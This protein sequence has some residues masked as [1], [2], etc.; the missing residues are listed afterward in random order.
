MEAEYPFSVSPKEVPE[1]NV[2]EGVQITI[3]FYPEKT[4]HY[5]GKL[6]LGFD[7]INSKIINLHGLGKSANV[8]LDTNALAFQN[9]YITCNT[10]R[11]MKIVN[12]SNIRVNFCWKL[13]S[14]VDD[15]ISFKTRS[16]T[17]LALEHE[18]T[19]REYRIKKREI[20]NDDL[21]FRDDAFSIYPLKGEIWPNQELEISVDFHPQKEIDYDK[22]AFCE[23]TGREIRLP[24]RL[25]GRGRG[26]NVSFSYTEISIGEIFINSVHEY[27][28]RLDNKGQIGASFEL[29]KPTSLF[30]P[31]FQFVPA[32]GY[33]AATESQIIKIFFSSDII[34]SFEEDIYFRIEGR[35]EDLR[36][37][38]SGQIIGPTFNFDCD[39]LNFGM[40][41]YGFLNTK[42]VNIINTCEIP[43]KFNLRIPEDGTMLKRQFDIIP[44]N[45]SILPHAKKQIKIEY[46]STVLRENR[47]TLVVDVEGVGDAL[48]AIP[49][50]AVTVAP[51][52][53]LAKT[54]I[55]FGDC[56][57]GYEYC[58]RL[59]LVNSTS[60]SSK[61]E[62]ILPE[63]VKQYD[64]RTDSIMGIVT[65]KSSAF[66][67]IYFK[68]K[69]LGEISFKMF[70]KV[71]GSEQDP[72]EVLVTAHSI[73]PIVRLSD[74]VIDFGKVNVLEIQHAKLKMSNNSPIPANYSAQ[75]RGKSA[76]IFSSQSM[77]G[78]IEPKGELDFI[79][80]AILDD[81]VKFSD[82]LLLTIE[83]GEKLSVK[84]TAIGK[85]NT[86]IPTEPIN[87]IDFG[88]Q[89]TSRV[90]KK[91][92]SLENKSRKPQKISWMQER[93]KGDQNVPVFKIS[94]DRVVIPPK[95]LQAFTIEGFCEKEGEIAEPWICKMSGKKDIVISNPVL[96]SRISIPLLKFSE[97][98]LSFLYRYVKGVPATIQTKTVDVTNISP[99]PLTF[100]VK[101]TPPF[102][103]SC[104]DYTI[105]PG[106]VKTLEVQF[107]P[108][109]KTDKQSTDVK[110]KM[111]ITYSDHPNKSAI[112][113]LGTVVFPNLVLSSTAIDFGTVVADAE[114]SKTITLENRGKL[115]A[116]FS[117]IFEI[118]EN[119]DLATSQ[120]FDILPMN[121]ILEPGESVDIRFVYNA[122]KFGVNTAT[123]ICEVEGGPNYIMNLR[124]ESSSVKFGVDNSELDYGVIPYYSPQ[125]KDITISNTGKIAI[126]FN[127]DFGTLKRKDI[128]QVIPESGRI[129]PGEKQKLIVKLIPGIPEIINEQFTLMVAMYEP[130]IV[131]VKAVSVHPMINF[132]TKVGKDDQANAISYSNQQDFEKHLELAQKNASRG[133]TLMQEALKKLGSE[134]KSTS[135]KNLSIVQSDV[136]KEAERLLF[137]EYLLM[138]SLRNSKLRSIPRSSRT[139]TPN[140]QKLEGSDIVLQRVVVDFGSTI[141]GL[142]KKKTFKLTNVGV[143]PVYLRFDKKELAKYG[144]SIEPSEISNLPGYPD[145]QSTPID[146]IFQSKSERVEIGEYKAIIPI[147]VLNGYIIEIEARANVILPE[148]SISETSLNFGDVNVGYAK[149]YTIQIYNDKDVNSEWAIESSNGR[150]KDA[151]F[152]FDVM[153][154]VLS[155]GEKKNISITFMPTLDKKLSQTFFL[156]CNYNPQPTKITCIGNGK[157]LNIKVDYVE[158]ELGPILPYNATFI[159]FSISN[160]SECAIDVY[161]VDFDE[162]YRRESEIILSCDNFEKGYILAKP[163]KFGGPL[164]EDILQKYNELV[165]KESGEG[166]SQ[167]LAS[168]RSV[169]TT[170][171]EPPKKRNI[172]VIHGPP[173]S[174]KSEIATFISSKLNIPIITIDSAW[175]DYCQAHTDDNNP[176]TARPSSSKTKQPNDSRMYDKLGLALSERFSQNDCKNGFIIDGLYSDRLTD[177]ATIT[178]LIMEKLGPENANLIC[179]DANEAEIRSRAL[180]ER[181]EKAKQLME[182]SR[183]PKL[184][185]E[186]YET[187]AENEKKMYEAQIKTFREN[188]MQYDR[189]YADLIRLEKELAGATRKYISEVLAERRKE[190]EEYMKKM[191]EEAKKKKKP[192]PNTKSNTTRPETPTNEK[193]NYTTLADELAVTAEDSLFDARLKYFKQYYSEVQNSFKKIIPEEPTTG[194][195]KNLPVKKKEEEIVENKIFYFKVSGPT[196]PELFESLIQAIPA[197]EENAVKEPSK[198]M[199]LAIP[200]PY[201]LQVI[202]KPSQIQPVNTTCPFTIVSSS[203]NEQSE[204]TRWTISPGGKQEL[205]IKFTSKQIGKFDA[206]LTFGIYG[207]NTQFSIKTSGSC[208]YP[209]ISTYYKNIFSRRIKSRPDKG[210]A[211]KYVINENNYEF[212]PLLIRPSYDNLDENTFKEYY[213]VFRFTNSGKFTC[214]LNFSLEKEDKTFLISPSQLSIN[215][216]A[217][218]EVKVWALPKI[219]GKLKN[220][221]ICTV[222]NNPTPF[223]FDVS[224]TGSKPKIELDKTKIDFGKVLLSSSG[225]TEVINMKN[226]AAIP[227][228]WSIKNKAQIKKEFTVE[229]SEGKLQPGDQVAIS[230]KFITDIACELEEKLLLAIS[231]IQELLPSEETPIQLKAD[232]FGMDVSMDCSLDFGTVKVY[233]SSSKTITMYNNGKYDAAF[234][235]IIPDKLKPHFTINPMEGVLTAKAKQKTNVEVTFKTNTEIFYN[236]NKSIVCN[237][238]DNTTKMA[239]GITALELSVK[240]MFSKFTITPE[241]GI[242]FGP[243]S[244]DKER[245]RP[246]EIFNTGI[247]DIQYTVFDFSKGLPEQQAEAEKTTNDSKKKDQKKVKGN[248][249]KKVETQLQI[250][251][252]TI[253]PTVGTIAPG[254]KAVVNVTFKGDGTKVFQET[255]GIDISD[256]NMDDQPNGIPYSLQGESC[257]P[258]IITNEFESIFEEQQIVSNM[259][260]IVN[261]LQ[262]SFTLDERIFSFGTIAVGKK[263]NEK[264]KIIN[265]FKVPCNVECSV[266]P[267]DMNGSKDVTMFDVVPPKLFIPPHEH[268][269][270]TLSFMPPTMNNYSAIFEATVT[271][272]NDPKTKDLRIEIRGE[273]SL[274]QVVIKIPEKVGEI[275]IMKFPKTAVGK[276]EELP[277]LISNEGLLPA[278]VRFDFP[279]HPSL[280]FPER[281]E[282]FVLNSKESRKFTMI[283]EPA[284]AE[285]IETTLNMVVLDNHFEDTSIKVIAESIEE[286]VIMTQLP[287][288]KENEL[289]FGDCY[290]ASNNER[291]F[292]VENH[293]RDPVRFEF[294]CPEHITISPAAG[295]IQAKSSKDVMITFTTDEPLELKGE[296]LKCI[297]KK[298]RFTSDEETDWDDRH[299]SIKWVEIDE[300]EEARKLKEL[301][302]KKRREKEEKENEKKGTKKKDEKKPPQKQKVEEKTA[303]VV[304]EEPKP[305]K[306]VTKRMEVT[307]PEPLHE[308]IGDISDKIL[309]IYAVADYAKFEIDKS[310][311]V[312]STTKMFETRVHQFP[313]KNVGKVILNFSWSGNQYIDGPFEL[314]PKQ[315]Q[316]KPGE[317]TTFTI[318]YAP[319]DVDRHEE[320]FTCYIDNIMPTVET[321]AIIVT[322]VSTCPLV[323]FEITPSDYL[324]SGRRKVLFQ[325]QEIESLVDKEKTRVIELYSCGIKVKNTKRF[326]ILNPTDVDFKYSWQKIQTETNDNNNGDNSFSCLTRTGIINSGKKSEI[327]FEYIPYSLETKESLWM[328]S[329]PSRKLN[330]PF[331]VVG[332][333]KEPEVFLDSARVNFQTVLVGAKSSQVINIIN[334]EPIP[335]SF[336][337]DQHEFLEDNQN[338]RRPVLVVSPKSGTVPADQTLP[339]TLVYTPNTETSFNI[340]LSCRVKK[341]PST[342]SCNVKGEGFLVHESLEVAD[343]SMTK[344]IPLSAKETNEVDFERAQINEKKIKK[345]IITNHG[346]YNFDFQWFHAKNKLITINPEKGTVFKGGKL[347][348]DIFFNPTSQVKLENYKCVCKITNSNSY[349]VNL[350]GSGSQ[351]KINFS[352][353][354][355]DFGAHFLYHQGM[356]KSP[357]TM[358]KIENC[359]EK[360]ISFEMLYDNKPHL[361]VEASATVLKPGESRQIKIYFRP[362]EIKMYKETVL[363]EI[364]GLYKTSV[365]IFG[366]GTASKVELSNLSD[367]I[368]NLGSIR[369]GEVV[370]KYLNITNKSKITANVSFLKETVDQLSKC[371]V[372]LSPK[373]SFSILPRQEAQ[374]GLTF[375]PESRLSTFNV[376]LNAYIDG[377][378]KLLSNITGS[379]QG[380]EVKLNTSTVAFGPVVQHTVV[381]N[382]V[383]MENTGDIG[384]N[385]K[386]NTKGLNSAFTI[387]PLQ[388]FIPP[389]EEAAFEVTYAPVKVDSTGQSAQ[390]E[391]KIDSLKD[392][393]L[394]TISGI[395]V[396]KPKE[397]ETLSFRVA[398]RQK[399][400][401]TVKIENPTKTDWRLKPVIDNPSWSGPEYLELPANSV[402]EYEITYAPLSMTLS[403]PHKGTLFFPLPDGKAILYE[404]SGEALDPLPAGSIVKELYAKEHHIETLFVENWLGKAQRFS[405]ILDDL[406]IKSPNQLTAVNYIDVPPISKREY[407]FSFLPFKDGQF[408]GKVRFVNVETKEFIYYNVKFNVLKARS[409]E[410]IVMETPVRQKLVKHVTVENPLDKESILSVKCDSTE[411]VVAPELRIPAKSFAKCEFIYLPLL[412]VEPK[413]AKLTIGNDELGVFPFDLLLKPLPKAA[414]RSTHFSVSL[415]NAQ[416]QTVRFVNYA[417]QA[418]EYTCK[419]EDN[420]TDF[421]LVDKPVMKVSPATS[422]E[423]NEVGLDVTYEPTM[424][425]ASKAKLILTS[426]IGGEYV[427]WLFGKCSPPR[428]QGP[429]EI[430]PNGT[431][432]ITFKN[433]F[434]KK[435]DFKFSIEDASNSFSVKPDQASLNVKQKLPLTISYKPQSSAAKVVN[436]AKLTISSK[437]NQLTW[438]YY[439]MGKPESSST[440]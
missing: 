413:K 311:I 348:C 366:E 365:V 23:I 203:E 433:V 174:F 224:C 4:Q 131:S 121:G 398:V 374:I 377:R 337:F 134:G 415:G 19:S 271:D 181:V 261:P 254:S 169:E 62:I 96:K 378:I 117:W 388:G 373:S 105:E 367:K 321:P 144:L 44:S 48:V 356:D 241:S 293:A 422:L 278:T 423:G 11:T 10:Q 114:K 111:I 100:S 301:E 302:E 78:T 434:D 291:T 283:Y 235:F 397:K 331:L 429:I 258:G 230:V 328:F 160:N 306:L 122:V 66:V 407:K 218:A 248:S 325:N 307:D 294:I 327:I 438:L 246:F 324:T 138:N 383:I 71:V 234:K 156:K 405:V 20:E 133:L 32:S 6:K 305:K 417:R 85:G 115:S 41:P 198:K 310:D 110:S 28:I 65:N 129:K 109:Y 82:D 242:N 400:T 14:V 410:E 250:G 120:I 57:I 157:D 69:V 304:Q 214:D 369:A 193:I 212:G 267:R 80:D 56:F 8:K 47:S 237:L 274:P 73:G 43:M 50:R 276:R 412:A 46:L 354:Q 93:K 17:Q 98:S 370:T 150:K 221:I 269:Y 173:V 79:I 180:S 303:P 322:G 363:F 408:E 396:E 215:P 54:E 52:I 349:V 227:I 151:N 427:F 368:L 416:T 432:Q 86:V 284:E 236:K 206:V 204:T 401:K 210:L 351:P 314:E 213:D 298:I 371:F 81:T 316:I 195:K 288:G 88:D 336:A 222:K 178:K 139:T 67:D 202:K 189:L 39:E 149:V 148:I 5:Y 414:E 104:T 64:C 37:H 372:T 74:P 249:A 59:E 350:S 355:Y 282:E 390:I 126:D 262:S 360:D 315:G 376:E 118:P 299:K 161:S 435:S 101:A 179:L 106:Q 83:N 123:A 382:R 418:T 251:Q 170:Q 176:T 25:Q 386:W 84:L 239:L 102:S 208:S 145:N 319:Q 168:A 279:N 393:V 77:S 90:F 70:V 252:F 409:N 186:E 379:C 309:A 308:I 207:R 264:I 399:Q 87:E 229:P 243:L 339:I 27:E 36:L 166:D 219:V 247:F 387:K 330:I 430:Q 375:K 260:M 323:H 97:T 49:I 257:V 194:N 159:P 362:R 312:F 113:L 153:E 290:V 226:M 2:G 42:Y 162:Q 364:N 253:Q 34:G 141:K 158:K 172:Y 223:K 55:R 389:N 142:T 338:D 7:T 406:N 268:R 177:Q 426:P 154:G 343:E 29:I 143:L 22:I 16:I 232:A 289:C 128:I 196:K 200:E 164:N 439:L 255:L 431:A 357:S 205:F 361:E 392:P 40:V 228:L 163:R 146:I 256:R 91:I 436:H 199:E 95:T 1:L 424:T 345:I 275:P 296:Q 15:E 300:E 320:I 411:I 266:K 137:C 385:Y 231:D 287:F 119:G 381:V 420:Q 167:A 140:S 272:G 419:F 112:D 184:T 201:L 24:L 116:V 61:Y 395:C 273:G 403:A 318:K 103:L 45:G 286:D 165:K 217:T 92:V 75:F 270:V 358:L 209:E 342:L 277:V 394:L 99:L 127:F 9:T 265:P 182:E 192:T 428:P 380:I 18:E 313:L 332:H 421:S 340:Q 132:T 58:E 53:T 187:L 281:L 21:S 135:F 33:V 152:L 35:H 384:I 130:I 359:D 197:L 108:A 425:G 292:T 30:G 94:P 51:T 191:E 353:L 171:E 107:N 346:N 136:Q 347:I 13:F 185:E 333:A 391:C 263:V 60:M 188:K 216:D 238:Q 244:Y 68:S 341:K 240:S 402:R 155:P 437:G 38:F 211:K 26:P 72:F 124:G 233:D 285:K 63:E 404:L 31:K 175:N 335:F 280:L 76:G 183:Y 147:K 329:I 334:R 225:Y 344:I 190:D 297:L 259:D 295:H 89:F 125:E 317:Q 3:D 326:Y 352:F 440:K 245:Q 220:S 12:N